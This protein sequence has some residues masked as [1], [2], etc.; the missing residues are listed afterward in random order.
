MLSLR[1]CN[2]AR[3]RIPQPSDWLLGRQQV[4]QHAL[5]RARIR[6][7]SA[8]F[9]LI[10]RPVSKTFPS[11]ENGEPTASIGADINL[12]AKI[13]AR[14]PYEMKPPVHAK[15]LGSGP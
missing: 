7:L 3:S 5:N 9:F 13:C 1:A 14:F 6:Q 11:V 12:D 8:P 2:P 4:L 10:Q 15:G